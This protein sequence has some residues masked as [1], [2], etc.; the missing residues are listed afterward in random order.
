MAAGRKPPETPPQKLP[1]QPCQPKPCLHR[2]SA[3]LCCSFA[4]MQRATQSMPPA[5]QC[6]DPTMLMCAEMAARVNQVHASLVTQA[7]KS[8]REVRKASLL[9]N[10]KALS[11]AHASVLH[12]QQGHSFGLS[13]VAALAHGGCMPTCSARCTSQGY[14]AQQESKQ[15]TRAEGGSRVLLMHWMTTAVQHRC[16][17]PSASSACRSASS[18]RKMRWMSAS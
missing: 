3:F 11:H 4:C 17:P 14:H 18:C 9:G 13:T 10:R 16:S 15:Q 8:L 7:R 5:V 6:H 1:P 12:M 2:A